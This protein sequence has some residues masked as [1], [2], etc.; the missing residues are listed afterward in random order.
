MKIRNGFVS[1]SSSS[2]FVIASK[3][4]PVYT[5]TVNLADYANDTLKTEE[6]VREYIL[7][8]YWGRH[9]GT[10]EE[11]FDAE[12]WL[13]ERYE[14]FVDAINRGETI[15]IVDVSNTDDDMVRRSLYYDGLPPMEDVTILA[16]V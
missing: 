10:M 5:V 9:E 16:G 15:Y 2:S 12:P 1:N 7:L 4:Q 11:V 8:Y 3:A 6:E 13:K 14:D